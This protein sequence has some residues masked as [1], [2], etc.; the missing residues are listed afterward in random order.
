M[1][2]GLAMRNDP[3]INSE[4][5]ALWADRFAASSSVPEPEVNGRAPIPLW[6]LKP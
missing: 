6:C 1:Q 4:L 2:F 5:H 3:A